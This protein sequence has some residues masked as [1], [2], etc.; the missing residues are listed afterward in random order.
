MRLPYIKFDENTDYTEVERIVKSAYVDVV[1]REN[2]YFNDYK[3][4][5]YNLNK[6]VEAARINKELGNI[7]RYQASL[8]S[9]Y[10][11]AVN[12]NI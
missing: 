1:A 8:E 3:Y 12:F 6:Y 10:L 2:N 11:T 9:A 4:V 5:I 7:Q